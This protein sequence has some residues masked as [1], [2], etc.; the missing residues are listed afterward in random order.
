MKAIFK[1]AWGYQ[2]DV[3]NLPVKNIDE[4]VAFYE[5]QLGFRVI[6]KKDVPVRSVTLGRDDIQIALNEN[7]GDPAQDGSFFEVDDVETAF[8]ELKANR[9]EKAPSDFSTEQHGGH[10]WKAF[11]IVAPDGLCYCLGE[12]KV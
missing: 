10:S 4:A 9:L 2:G 3:L 1:K 11:Y 5:N 7:G 8:N 6:S 12:R